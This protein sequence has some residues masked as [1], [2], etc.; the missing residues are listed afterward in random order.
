MLRKSIA[1]TQ[2]KFNNISPAKPEENNDSSIISPIPSVNRP[3]ID[4]GNAENVANLAQIALTCKR[5]KKFYFFTGFSCQGTKKFSQKMSTIL[6]DEFSLFDEQMG[7]NVRN[8]SLI[9]ARKSLKIL[10][11]A[12]HLGFAY[13]NPDFLGVEQGI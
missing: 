5:N 10:K 2:A 8:S 13:N 3:F 12:I 4:P 11:S 6:K 7:R 9:G 1:Y